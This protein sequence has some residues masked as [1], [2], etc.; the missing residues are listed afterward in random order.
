MVG[1][2][3]AFR[4]TGA[5][6]PGGD[7]RPTHHAEMEGWFWRI[8]APDAG[9]VVVALCGINRHADGPWATTAIAVHPGAVTRSAALPDAAASDTAFEVV[10]PGHLDA[11]PSHLRSSIDDVE[12]DVALADLREW[13]LRLGGGGLFSAVP[14]LSQYWHPHVLGGRASGAVSVAGERFELR[15]ARVY[16]EKNWGAGFPSHWW[17]GEA[18]DF[19]DG[20]DV[21]VA[22]GGGH[23]QAGPVG[24]DVGGCVMRVGARVL[25]FAPPAALVRSH[26][27]LES[28]RWTV[29]ARRPGWRLDV[30]GHGDGR[31]PHV[32]PVPVPSERRNIDTDL[33]HLAGRMTVTLQRRGHV[34]YRGTSHL[35]GLEIG[36]TDDALAARQRAAV[37]PVLFDGLV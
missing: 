22:F 12:L 8:T 20:A 30:D 16:A 37:T 26:V 10:V 6:L 27:D 14:W 15:D 21:C 31:M 19:D 5:D 36:T 17:W 29:V 3:A 11:G 1:L 18:H 24:A 2:S 35:A 25:R 33:E 13:P 9:R 7:P 4:R 32:L 34:V 28:G 23:L